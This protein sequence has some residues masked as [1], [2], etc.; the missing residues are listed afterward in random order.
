MCVCVHA[1]VRAC[2]LVFMVVLLIASPL[3][4]LQAVHLAQTDCQAQQN[5]ENWVN[6]LLTI[7]QCYSIFIRNIGVTHVDSQVAII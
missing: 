7:W 6:L 4:P 2:V 1:C 5:P 3:I